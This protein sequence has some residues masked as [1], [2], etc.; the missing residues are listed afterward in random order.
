MVVTRVTMLF[1]QA[2][3]I[4][5]THLNLKNETDLSMVN[6]QI[7]NKILLNIKLVIVTFLQAVIVL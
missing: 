5:Q 7:S 3:C 1:L 4:N 2:G 6:V